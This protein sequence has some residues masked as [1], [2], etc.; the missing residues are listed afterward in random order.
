MDLIN[1]QKTVLT[2]DRSSIKSDPPP[3]ISLFKRS[4]L[5][6]IVDYICTCVHTY[7]HIC[8]YS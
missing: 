5:E 3:V 2:F 1:V 7:I 6:K 8:M 4:F